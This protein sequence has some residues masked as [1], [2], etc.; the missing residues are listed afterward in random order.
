LNEAA[1]YLKFFN[2]GMRQRPIKLI[3]II[4]E[5]LTCIM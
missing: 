1:L 4:Q 3:Q 2:F 5:Q